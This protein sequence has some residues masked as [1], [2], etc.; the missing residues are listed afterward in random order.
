MVRKMGSGRE[1][2]STLHFIARL[3]HVATSEQSLGGNG[4][5]DGTVAVSMH[6]LAGIRRHVPVVKRT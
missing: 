5:L 1:C 3:L 2:N 6:M 4:S